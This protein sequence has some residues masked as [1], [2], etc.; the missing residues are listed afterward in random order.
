[1][2]FQTMMT[3]KSKVREYLIEMQ[4]FYF[5]KKEISKQKNTGFPLFFDE[6]LGLGT[7]VGI[8]PLLFRRN[9]FLRRFPSRSSRGRWRWWRGPTVSAV[10]TLPRRRVVIIDEVDDLNN[11]LA[12]GRSTLVL[13]VAVFVSEKSNIVT[14]ICLARCK[15][16]FSN[17]LAIG[18]RT[19]TL[20]KFSKKSHNLKD[21]LLQ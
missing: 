21:V 9:E 13:D 19:D 10:T 15:V 11:R 16:C 8:S 20:N 7:V 17:K 3:R 1:M 2:L 18:L 14:V 12:D 6:N 4:Y 5:E